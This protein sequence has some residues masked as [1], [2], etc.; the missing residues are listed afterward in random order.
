M[1]SNSTGTMVNLTVR[2]LKSLWDSQ[3]CWEFQVET[4]SNVAG[5]STTGDLHDDRL[6]PA[7]TSWVSI[8][9]FS[10]RFSIWRI[11]MCSEIRKKKL[12]M[13]ERGGKINKG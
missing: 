5:E 10:C 7:V 13:L 4:L 2:R 11:K 6:P 8:C 9:L 3:R 1:S 12:F